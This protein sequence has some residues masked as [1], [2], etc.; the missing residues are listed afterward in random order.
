MGEVLL[1]TLRCERPSS[2]G[3]L[4]LCAGVLREAGVLILRCEALAEP[5]R[6][7]RQLDQDEPRRVNTQCIARSALSHI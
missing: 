4:I 5:R 7:G 2:V 3:V 6:R 1:L